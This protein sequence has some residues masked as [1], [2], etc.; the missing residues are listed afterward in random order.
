MGMFFEIL[1]SINDPHRQG[2]VDQLASIMSDI[3]RLQQQQNLDANTTQKLMSAVGPAM[4]SVLKQQPEGGQYLTQLSIDANAAAMQTLF[5][6][7]M[8]TQIAQGMVQKTGM[9]SGL[10]QSIV[11]ALL[12]LVC[13]LFNMGASQPGMNGHSTNH[14]LDLFMKGDD[15]KADLG[16]VF[17]FAGRFLS[18]A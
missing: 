5:T 14:V 6:P 12:P 18:L 11:P 2:S 1:N 3:Q 7:A 13:Q 17:K 9:C 4:Q 10:I 8:Q 16:D 15:D